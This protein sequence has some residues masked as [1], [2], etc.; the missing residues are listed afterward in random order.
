MTTLWLGKGVTATLLREAG[1][2]AP[3]ETGGVLLGWRSSN[4]ICVTTIVGPGPEAH[5]DKTSFD[6][7]SEWQ[8]AQIAQLYAASGR[9]LSYL[10]D[11]H[12]HPGATP[13]PSTRDHRTLR[14]IARHTPA[15]C[16]EPIMVILGQPHANQWVTAGY[17]II[18][19]RFL[20]SRRIIDLPPYIDEEQDGF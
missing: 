17:S 13:T 12:T 9:R 5:H 16:P 15:R 7:D 6:P 18:R 2:S 4:H 20:R 3:L 8:A 10:G 1:R 14:A 19:T 11:W